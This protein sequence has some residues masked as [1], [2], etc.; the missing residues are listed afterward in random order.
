MGLYF[1]AFDKPPSPLPSQLSQNQTGMPT[2]T[3]VPTRKK[4][5]YDS[6]FE[7][8][9]VEDPNPIMG[10][11]Y[12]SPLDGIPGRQRPMIPKTEAEMLKEEN[13]KK[14]KKEKA[15]LDAKEKAAK[16]E[17]EIN[18]KEEKIWSDGKE[19]SEK[20][21]AD[22]FAKDIV[23]IQ[24]KEDKMMEKLETAAREKAEW[25]GARKDKERKESEA[26]QQAEKEK[27][28][29]LEEGN[30]EKQKEDKGSP[31]E[32]I[33]KDEKAVNGTSKDEKLEDEK[34]KDEPPKDNGPS[35]K[36]DNPKDGKPIDE[37]SKDQKLI[38]EKPKDEKPEE[39]KPA[40]EDTKDDKPK[41]ENPKDEKSKDDPPKKDKQEN[42]SDPKEDSSN[43]KTPD[44]QL[45]K[46]LEEELSHNDKTDGTKPDWEVGLKDRMKSL[47]VEEEK[48][49]APIM[50]ALKEAQEKASQPKKSQHND[51]ELKKP[52]SKDEAEEEVNNMLAIAKS[53]GIVEDPKLPEDD[54]IALCLAV[55]DQAADLVEFF[56]HHYHHLG[57]RRFYIMDDRSEP[58]LSTVKEDWGIPNEYITFD[59]QSEY[60]RSDSNSEQRAI[61]SRC[62][63]NWGEK[64]VWMGFFDAD[65]FL[66]MTAGNETLQEMLHGFQKMNNFGALAI[67]WR[68]H[69]SSGHKTRQ[70][71][72]RKAYVD[73]IWDDDENAGIGSNN[74]HVKVIVRTSMA[75]KPAGPHM[76]QLSRGYTMG[77][78]MDIVDSI[79]WRMPITRDR[80][81][82]HHYAGKSREEY[83]EKMLRG[84]A[85]DDPK[86]EGFWNSLENGLPKVPCPEMAKCDP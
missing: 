15:K 47:A 14:Q 17:K 70:E 78:H 74:S 51:I 27:A 29:K 83:E 10:E 60:I 63:K 2:G 69:T 66:E 1:V 56:I 55:K 7:D 33:S 62:M 16:A 57:I 48:L 49:V 39:G 76:W 72:V 19:K 82:L 79:A 21:K 11:E 3:A 65:E 38:D 46:D 28:Q 52:N 32:D 42:E 31:K 71:S 61:Y 37:K 81:A 6:R 25:V 45:K 85:M 67:N 43:E 30:T 34:T 40:D 22:N 75:R 50:N 8:V 18:A 77:E 35:P 26:K 53:L 54:Y 4:N 5:A 20:E 80:I 23:E 44:D 68:M 86:G 36:E 84:N 64:H 24:D 73:C 59:D 9:H 13:E 12:D 41:V 58:P